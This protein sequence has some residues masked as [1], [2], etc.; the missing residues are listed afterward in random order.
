L[1][2]EHCEVR[3]DTKQRAC[4]KALPEPLHRRFRLGNLHDQGALGMRARHRNDLSAACSSRWQP[5]AVGHSARRCPGVPLA[6]PERV[7]KPRPG[8]A[9]A[10]LSAG[11]HRC[12]VPA[13]VVEVLDPRGDRGPCLCPDGGG[14]CAGWA[15][16]GKRAPAFCMPCIPVSS[17]GVALGPVAAVQNGSNIR[18]R[19]ARSG[20]IWARWSFVWSWIVGLPVNEGATVAARVTDGTMTLVGH[21]HGE[22]PRQMLRLS[23]A[24]PADYDARTLVR[25]TVAH[26][27]ERQF[28]GPTHWPGHYRM[29]R[30]R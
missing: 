25:E 24:L 15:G 26:A 21:R 3:G 11:A 29:S 17:D 16:H 5:A 18:G 27:A 20:G 6:I 4:V 23:D 2:G 14:L 28:G 7:D 8:H 22:W 30:S 19:L 1:G 13:D 10:L 9:H 12:G